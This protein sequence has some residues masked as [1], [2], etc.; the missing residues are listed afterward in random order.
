MKEA[1][2]G[3]E[4]INFNGINITDI[5]YADDAVSVADKRTNMQKM[6]DSLNDMC[7]V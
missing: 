4:D 1:M 7:H 3:M 5:R 2:E 6:A